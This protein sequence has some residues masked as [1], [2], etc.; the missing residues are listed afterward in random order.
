MS[1]RSSL[2][3]LRVLGVSVVNARLL[4]LTTEA[5]RTRRLHREIKAKSPSLTCQLEETAA[6]DYNAGLKKKALVTESFRGRARLSA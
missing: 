5:Q 2:C 3:N 6:N 1:C 4:T